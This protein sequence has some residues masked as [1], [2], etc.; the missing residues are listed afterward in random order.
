MSSISVIPGSEYER[1]ATYDLVVEFEPE[2]HLTVI[3]D[4]KQR[5]VL[6]DHLRVD[7]VRYDEPD[8]PHGFLA[9]GYEGCTLDSRSEIL[10]PKSRVVSISA[11][12]K[13]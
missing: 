10:V 11:V 3:H 4:G 9:F 8:V 6:C 12:D 2:T 7:W 13:V 1:A 5:R